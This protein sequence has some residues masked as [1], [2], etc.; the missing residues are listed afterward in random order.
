VA[1]LVPG[2]GTRPVVTRSVRNEGQAGRDHSPA[3]R[4]VHHVDAV[5]LPIRAGNAEEEGEPTPETEPALPGQ[6]PLEDKLVALAPKIT[7]LLLG[8]S[9]E[10]DLKV[11]PDT[12]RK[13]HARSFAHPP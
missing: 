13:L 9:V 11:R 10:E 1:V 2:T 5:V 12:S 7:T 8:D 6:P 4:A 3:I